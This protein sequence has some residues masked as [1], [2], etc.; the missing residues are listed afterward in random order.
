MHRLI[1]SVHK[2]MKSAIG[3]QGG[4]TPAREDL[5]PAAYA[6]FAQEWRDLGA[7]ILGGCCGIGPVVGAVHRIKLGQ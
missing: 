1:R 7:D 3:S 4:Q 6:R 2:D 5:G